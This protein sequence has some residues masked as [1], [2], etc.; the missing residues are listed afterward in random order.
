VQNYLPLYIAGLARAYALRAHT[1]RCAAARK[2]HALFAKRH[3]V[4]RRRRLQKELQYATTGAPLP[5]P[6]CAAGI[7]NA[8]P[9]RTETP[10]Q[11][12]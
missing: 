8:S 3:G 11:K 12:G 10:L 7:R 6:T 1:R 4:G 5:A 2:R 9:L